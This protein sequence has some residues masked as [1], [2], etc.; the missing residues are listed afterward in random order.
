MKKKVRKMSAI[1]FVF[2]LILAGCCD[3]PPPKPVTDTDVDFISYA[4]NYSILIQNYTN[5]RLVAFKG[6]LKAET[7]V[8]G[9]PAHAR[10]HGLRNNPH[11]FDKTEDFS[12]ILL[13]EAQYKA[14]KN[15][16]SSLKYTPF[17]RLFVFYSKDGDN[18]TVY[19]IADVLGGNNRLEIINLSYGVNVELRIYG[20]AGDTLCYVPAGILDT[21]FKV[22]DGIY[23]IYPVFKRYN[24]LY[25]VVET[26]YPI[27][28]NS[29]YAWFKAYYLG[30]E[31]TSEIIN[32]K[33][34]LQSIAFTSATAWVRVVNQTTSGGIRFLEGN[35]VRSTASGLKV[36][37]NGNPKTFQIDMPERNF[38]YADSKVAAN[39]RF[40]R[41]GFEVA[42]QTSETDA[43]VVTSMTIE[44]NKMYTV[45]VSGSY[46][47][48]T[49][50]AYVSDISD[51][52]ASELVGRW[53]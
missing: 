47:D 20:A 18:T 10:Y 8:G 17:T 38:G 22:Q 52:P 40:G 39:W 37:N 42:L 12:L 2:G 41:T 48:N 50:K 1:A 27:V 45:T 5:E 7:L 49:I 34:L 32:L 53:E 51:I 6:E 35:D 31:N 14:N 4:T 13:T 43:T 46:D 19:R 15:Y 3:P 23:E 28:T 36:I 30:E 33:S 21:T 25:D 24:R 26:V 11:L 9:I 16:L 44:R 29:N